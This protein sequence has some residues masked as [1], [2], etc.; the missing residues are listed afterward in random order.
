MIK[1][2]G[3]L[4]SLDLLDENFACDLKKCRGACCVL[5]D[6]GAPLLE[7]EVAKL[8]AI[9]HDIKAY[10]RPEARES[11]EKDGV[12]YID[13]DGEPVTQL[14][15]GKECVFTV[16]DKGIARCGIERAF[17]EGKT[18]FRKPVSCHLYP[19]RIRK[20]K[21]YDAVNYDRWIICKPAILLGNR[22]QLPVYRFAEQSLI[23]RFGETWFRELLEAAKIHKPEKT[24]PCQ[25][26]G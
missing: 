22:M 7:D 2:N 26:Q 3:T 24:N 16:F 12:S 6:S 15:E 21:D 11:I 10:L 13:G 1:I 9:Y 17:E 5:G 8:K 14:R 23:R 25:N 4:V 19:V 18:D 20:Y